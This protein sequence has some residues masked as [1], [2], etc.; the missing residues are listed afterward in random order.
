MKAQAIVE[1]ALS[2]LRVKRAGFSVSA[3]DMQLGF[4]KL[5][6]MIGHWSGA[7]GLMIP[8]RT[9]EEV[10][11]AGGADTYTIGT[12]GTLSTVRPMEIVITKL[13]SG[14]TEYSLRLISLELLEREIDK[15]DSGRPDSV[16]YEPSEPLGRLY[17]N[18]TLD[19]AYTLILWSLKPL[20]G[21]AELTTDDDLPT[22][23]DELLVSNL[24]VRLAPDYGKEASQT[25]KAM[26]Q[27]TMNQV[28]G[29]NLSSR[30]P[31]LTVDPALLSR[32]RFNFQSGDF[33]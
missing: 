8:Y 28:M 7:K 1:D 22:E 33:E 29:H 21:F 2:E 4:R 5:N 24:A 19:Q 15:S 16:H 27:Q 14:D 12:G 18:R 32:A 23:Y 6:R 9:R 31:T 26:A 11:I 17:F 20:T 10:A 13:K 30:V 3:D 25:T